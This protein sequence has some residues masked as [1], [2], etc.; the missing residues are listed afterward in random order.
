LRTHSVQ[1]STPTMQA[2]AATWRRPRTHGRDLHGA[3]RP[4]TLTCAVESLHDKQA[5]APATIDIDTHRHTHTHKHPR[6]THDLPLVSTLNDPSITSSSIQHGAQDWTTYLASTC[7]AHPLARGPVGGPRQGSQGA[8][9]LEGVG[10][11]ASVHAV[12]Q[13]TGACRQGPTLPHTAQAAAA[14]IP[15]TPCNRH[16]ARQRCKVHGGGGGWMHA[17]CSTPAP[18]PK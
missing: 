16:R 8:L 7:P 3:V 10:D 13:Q 17:Q 5:T 12:G 9:G 11:E 1:P 18:T 4:G 2:C 15:A 14:A 6:H